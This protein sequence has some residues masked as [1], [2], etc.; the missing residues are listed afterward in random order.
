MLVL[1]RKKEQSLMLGNDIEISVLSV[2]RDT[3]KLGI[4]APPH[5]QV[6]RKELYEQISKANQ[7]AADA[8]LEGFRLLEESSGTKSLDVKHPP[9]DQP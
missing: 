3:V 2:S 6:Y 4:K 5:V 7:A 1:S 8:E 9:G